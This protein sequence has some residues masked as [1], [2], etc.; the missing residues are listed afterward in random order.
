MRPFLPSLTQRLFLPV[1]RL[2]AGV[3]A[4][5]LGDAL[6]AVP[7]SL[8]PLVEAHC[9]ECHDADTKKGGLD[10]AAL[11][12]DLTSPT[13]LKTWV[14]VYD[15]VHDGEMPPA[16]KA[17]PTA[18]ELS[19]FLPDLS[20]RLTEA[21]RHQIAQNGR[22]TRRRLNR[23]EYENTVRD[24][25]HAPWLPLREALPEDGLAFRFN[26]IG[27]ALDVSH[28]QMARYLSTADQALR[29]A[30]G[31][32]AERPKPSVVRY[33]TRDQ[34]SYTGPMTFSVFNTAPERA[35]FPVLGFEGQPNV[36]SSKA[37]ISVGTNDSALHELEGVGVV[38]GSYEP[39]EPKFNQFRAPVAGRYKLRFHGYSVWVG[40][41]P[42]NKWFIPDLDT[43]SKG[44]RSEPITVYSEVPPNLLR[45]LGAFDVTPE[46]GVHELEVSLLAGETIRP[47]PARL[48]R[49]RP[50]PERWQNP[51]AEKDGQPGVV[52][53]WL[54][55]E[56][57]IY[58]TWPTLGHRLLFGSL[59]TKDR[60]AAPPT[61][62]TNSNRRFK[63]RPGVEVV[64]ENPQGDAET[65]L[66]RFTA[67]AYRRPVSSAEAVRFAPLVSK[68][69]AAGN[70]F[71]DSMLAAYT[72]VLSSP[73][74]IGLE[75]K[76]GRLDDFALAS[77]I[78]YFLWNTSPDAELRR[79]AEQGRL[80]RPE[81]LRA[82]TDRL[83]G[84]PRS[85]QFVDAFLDYWID[86]R[87]MDGTAPD[88]TLYPDY[89]LDD[90]L[91]DSALEETR[92]F[93]AELIRGNLPVKNLISSDFAMLN[94]RL[95]VHYGLPPFEGALHRKVALPPDSPRGGLLTQASVL[96]VT[97]NGTTTSPVL[98]GAWIMERL[99]GQP[100]PPPPPSVPA[101]EPDI[102]GAVTL[103]Q[104]LEKHR[105][106]A[107]CNACHARID[108]AGFALESFDVMGGWRD[109]YRADGP[110]KPAPGIG[111]SGQ[112]FTFHS[113]L[114]VD[115][116]GEL[117]DG[118][119]FK[120]IR[121]FKKLVLADQRQLARNLARQF[122]IYATGAPIHF[123]DRPE[124]ERILD[125]TAREG[126][127]VRSL[128]HELV[129][130]RL[131]R[132]K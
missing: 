54:E 129:Q 91:T 128:I 132:E 105:T 41:G 61:G 130:S 108:P 5:T 2:A 86:L 84:D 44:H 66:K 121:D 96:K 22:A 50:G 104:Q 34:R 47:D 85:R 109:R 3:V 98:R 131:F 64:S 76:P 83:L 45:R 51:L 36:R 14:K 106:Q 120:D 99:L 78:S 13:E 92:A 107:T 12:F 10:L 110:G 117:P 112:R 23:F 1:Y 89:Y 71:T 68:A 26:K 114:P 8:K 58:D 101:V 113:A 126:F 30:M 9:V 75:E 115:A 70:S 119:K 19:A 80:H 111:K 55:V 90:L 56:G 123:S 16:K 127:G 4:V 59:P 31:P 94:E 43:I 18:K 65:L 57:P 79:L 97:A 60:K 24:L 28:V 35:T 95:A 67:A 7:G 32:Q 62:D 53:R 73:E 25:L 74:F 77:R 48:F 72:A 6:A 103:R 39:I 49:S 46:P 42:T 21:D 52:F 122:T 125:R 63:P 81:T 20:Q 15:R 102:R 82:Q 93:F 88:T 29:S 116:T 11:Q 40:P 118:R 33:Y 100:P 87:K 38:A 37:P 69:M 27:E 124:I 17:R